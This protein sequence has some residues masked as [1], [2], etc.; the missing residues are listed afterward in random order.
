MD[1]PG[2][3]GE[4]FVCSCSLGLEVA[5]A[6]IAEGGVAPDGIIEAVDIMSNG[7]CGLAARLLACPPYQFGFNG[8][9]HGFHHRIIMAI[10]FAAHGDGASMVSPEL[11][12]VAGTILASSVGFCVIKIYA[13]AAQNASAN[14]LTG[15]LDFLLKI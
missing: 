7:G 9:E 2:E 14:S 4:R 11:L 8:L 6:F 12:V 1:L 5:R 15:L 3:S 10:A 13:S